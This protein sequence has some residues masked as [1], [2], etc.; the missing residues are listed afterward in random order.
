MRAWTVSAFGEPAEVLKLDENAEAPKPGPDQVSIRVEVAGLGLPDV[1]MCRNNYP[2][3][4][5]LPFTP[6]QE[7]VGEIIAVGANVETSVIGT[8]VL[9]PTLF[10]LQHG[11]LAEECLMMSKM[12]L[13]IPDTM[14]GAEAAGFFIPF[15]TAWIG[16]VHRAQLTAEDSVLILGASGSSGSA[17]VQLARAKGAHV[18]AVAGG[19]KK[20]A[21]CESLNADAV[22]DHRSEDITARTLELTDGKGVSVVYDPVGG[23][24]GRAAF[25][26]TAFEGRFVVIGYASGEWPRISLPETLP[27]NISLVGAMPVGYSPE[28]MLNIHNDLLSHWER[29]QLKVVGNQA[30]SFEEGGKAIEHIAAGKVEGK[31]VVRVGTA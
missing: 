17:A 7:A 16:L 26:A 28:F 23:K 22:I 3:V 31:V 13:P 19:A 20:V 2:L 11:G 24:A 14:S 29:G 21:F 18:I 25:K 4:P 15:Q 27:K 1:L 5:P 10:Q 6:S 8:R 9:G 12:A 30:F